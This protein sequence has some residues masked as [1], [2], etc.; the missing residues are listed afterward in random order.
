MNF[1]DWTHDINGE[2]IDDLSQISP[3]FDEARVL[4]LD[5]YYEL[6]VSILHVLL[7]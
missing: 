6:N 5:D 2:A 7:Q 3:G 1:Y 4:F